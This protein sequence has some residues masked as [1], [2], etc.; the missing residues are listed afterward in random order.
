MP[1]CLFLENEVIEETKHSYHKD[2]SHRFL[3]LKRGHTHIRHRRS[4]GETQSLVGMCC[5][6]YDLAI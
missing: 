4:A 6:Q 3:D 1:F 2:V 5:A